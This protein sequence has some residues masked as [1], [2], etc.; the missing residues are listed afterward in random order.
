M[1]SF[2]LTLCLHLLHL[3]P[4]TSHHS[5]THAVGVLTFMG[6]V[7]R[8]RRASRRLSIFLHICPS[9]GCAAVSDRVC[10]SCND[11]TS[12]AVHIHPRCHPR[13]LSLRRDGHSGV[14]VQS[15]LLR[16]DPHRLADQHVAPEGR[17]PGRRPLIGHCEERERTQRQLLALNTRLHYYVP[18]FYSHG[19][20]ENPLLTCS[21]FQ[22]A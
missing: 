5:L 8:E 14:R 9:E 22:R 15:R 17:V 3:P 10:V 16:A 1:S 19:N 18:A 13:G 4:A 7:A 11:V 2:H 21:M 12:G 20:C 6:A